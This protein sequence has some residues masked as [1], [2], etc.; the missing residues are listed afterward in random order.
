MDYFFNIAIV[1]SIP[2]LFY[3]VIAY[4]NRRFEQMDQ[5]LE[6]RSEAASLTT[7]ELKALVHEAVS[8]S[9]S[10]LLT[11]IE[12]NEQRLEGVEQLLGQPRRSQGHVEEH[13]SMQGSALLGTEPESDEVDL[14]EALPSQRRIRGT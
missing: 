11:R 7:T 13:R 2:L 8:E 14:G 3:F 10:V 6:R 1:I 12:Q 4:A 5:E 9:L